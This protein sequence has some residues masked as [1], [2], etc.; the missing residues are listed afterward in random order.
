VKRAFKALAAVGVIVALVTWAWRSQPP[1][2]MAR[3]QRVPAFNT[4]GVIVL[5][6]SGWPS[7][8]EVV[9]EDPGPPPRYGN[10]LRLD[11]RTG[12]TAWLTSPFLRANAM[13]GNPAYLA[14]T[15]GCVLLRSK[16]RWTLT[17]LKGRTLGQWPLWDGYVAWA[18]DGRSWLIGNAQGAAK[19][20]SLGRD[21]PTVYSGLP[22]M[23]ALAWFDGRG[24]AGFQKIGGQQNGYCIADLDS[25]DKRPPHPVKLP[26]ATLIVYGVKVSPRAD[27]LAWYIGRKVK[28]PAWIEW[29]YSMLH[30]GGAAAP[31]GPNGPPPIDTEGIWISRLDGTEM[32]EVGE[33]KAEWAPKGMGSFTWCPDGTRV[34]VTYRN[35]IYVIPVD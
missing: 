31:S 10:Y 5:E 11:I 30:V 29:L 19:L 35:G 17:T 22:G 1:S 32:R 8:H 9:F 12:V 28:Q 27:R 25:P 15:A 7:D 23:A 14:P 24:H 34:L 18:P 2:L 6:R 4:S 21:M 3:A 13:A 20:Y 16:A 26:P 33:V